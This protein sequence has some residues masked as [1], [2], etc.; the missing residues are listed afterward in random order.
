M[1]GRTIILVTHAVDLCLPLAAFLVTMSEGRIIL[2]ENVENMKRGGDAQGKLQEVLKTEES[3]NMAI[4]EGF[5]NGWVP[6]PPDVVAK[7]AGLLVAQEKKAQGSVAWPI[8]HAYVKSAGYWLWL[9]VLICLLA[10]VWS[11]TAVQYFL[12][13][14]GE[15]YG[16]IDKS[17]TW[18]HISP[19]KSKTAE[20]NSVPWGLPDPR[21]NVNPYLLILLSI[22][23][24]VALSNFAAELTLSFLGMRASRSMFRRALNKF[25][26]STMRWYDTTPAGRILNRF[27]GDFAILD[28]TLVSMLEHF[29]VT[30]L[31]YI[32]H[33][34]VVVAIVPW[35]MIPI[36]L[37]LF[38]FR[39]ISARYLSVSL[40]LKRL[41]SIH[42]SPIISQFGETLAGVTTI[43]AFRAE[44][45][46]I[47]KLEEKLDIY[48]AMHYSLWAAQRWV[49]IRFELIGLVA[50]FLG[51]V[52]AIHGDVSPGLAAM[53][54]TSAVSLAASTEAMM[55][56][57][58][59][60]EI[61]FNAVERIQELQTIPSEPPTVI[62][63]CRP[64]A[65]WPSSRGGIDIEQLRVSYSID[66]P[67]VLKGISLTIKGQEKIGVVGRTG[68]GKSTLASVLLRGMEPLSGRILID[69][70][71]VT[72][73]GTHDLRNQI[74]L[75]PQDPAVFSGTIRTNID[76]FNAY[77]DEECWS[78]LQRVEL[79]SPSSRSPQSGSATPSGSNSFATTV[80]DDGVSQSKRLYITSL[81]DAVTTNGG[82]LSAGQRQLLSLARALLRPSSIVILDEA[83]SSV[84]R[85]TDIK[86]QETLKTAFS[87]SIVLSIA[88]RLQTVIDCDKILVLDE[89]QVV[90][91]DAP[92]NLLS[93]E[94]G[95]FREM[96]SKR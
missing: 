73:I 69:G 87:S 78:A 77:S 11:E 3:I 29:S 27:S 16:P 52:L 74:T 53:V 4:H 13:I 45:Q 86:I 41:E 59:D 88:H 34:I 56:S 2:Q 43:R 25:I 36:G 38:V 35:F 62:E 30:V 9:I 90:E 63:A 42:K 75:I 55:K 54:I 94:G 33:I 58:G 61:N 1:N 49:Q 22:E 51:T 24:F 65:W 91:F 31:A 71:D 12:K 89:G 68:S 39:A 84:D 47:K 26:R 64:P 81:D 8:Y 6:T 19:L 70:I 79:A 37:L 5:T 17:A 80:E 10:R 20:K 7:K 72:T 21:E 15:A 96:W 46:F 23:V 18:S 83:T 50:V 28:T 85:E 14:W 67:E 32:R 93:K 48:L 57:F 82:N 60:L 66:T 92:A 40:E 95:V 44:K 76:P